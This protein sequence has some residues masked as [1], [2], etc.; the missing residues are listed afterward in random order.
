[1]FAT[2]DRG[3]R[4]IVATLSYRVVADSQLR[5]SQMRDVR[6]MKGRVLF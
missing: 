3:A 6:Q 1:M 5:K 2:V 4:R